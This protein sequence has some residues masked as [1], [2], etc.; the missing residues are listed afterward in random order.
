MKLFKQILPTLFVAIFISSCGQAAPDEAFFTAP[1]ET[2]QPTATPLP[3]ATLIPIEDLEL[4][5]EENPLIFTFISSIDYDLNSI[6]MDNL[7]AKLNEQTG[8]IYHYQYYPTAK[9]AFESLRQGEIHF[10][11]LHPITYVAAKER[12][13]VTPLYV[14][15]HYGLYEYG[16]Q[17]VAN[18]ESNFAI[19]YDS[20]TGQS[21][22]S[23]E[24]ALRQFEGKR[25]CFVNPSSLSGAIAANG[26]LL[27]HGNETKA[28]VYTQSHTATIR[29][30]YIK[31]ICDFGVTFAYTGDP[32][33]SNQVI[34]D[35]PDA[36]QQIQIL[37][38]S[39]PIIPSLSFAA[40]KDTPI[41]IVDKTTAFLSVF[42]QSQEGKEMLSSALHYDI[43]NLKIVEDA[44]YDTIR[45]LIYASGAIPY[46][47]L[48]Y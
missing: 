9:E 41:Q 30:L 38:K 39:D 17:F 5:T 31:D 16:F 46:Q 10:L 43:Q 35:L 18:T 23:A 36:Y 8:L 25:P 13:L 1:T 26:L 40:Y 19:Y 32:R 15:N 2:P 34:N 14:T 20:N 22:T 42:A 29:A 27:G 47:H 24:I 33:T 4:G 11:W 44:Y 48:G 28:P 6:S 12:D 21:D 37:W 7:L 3:T 45:N